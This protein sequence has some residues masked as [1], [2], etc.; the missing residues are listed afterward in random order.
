MES[1]QIIPIIYL[2]INLQ[3]PF[4]PGEGKAVNLKSIPGTQG[5]IYLNLGA[6]SQLILSTSNHV[7]ERWKETRKPED[8]A[9]LHDIW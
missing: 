6:I 9:K 7:I 2:L 3:W 4:Y 1:P 5:Y 8:H